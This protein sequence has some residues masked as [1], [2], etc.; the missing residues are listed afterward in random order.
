[1]NV[2]S[3]VLLAMRLLGEHFLWSGCVGNEQEKRIAGRPS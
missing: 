1:M 2:Q 3:T